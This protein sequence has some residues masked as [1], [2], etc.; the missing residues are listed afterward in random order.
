MTVLPND[1]EQLKVMLL[2][3]QEENQYKDEVIAIYKNS[4]PLM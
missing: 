3:L 4:D 1:V 2:K